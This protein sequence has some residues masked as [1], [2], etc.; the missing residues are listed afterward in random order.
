[1]VGYQNAVE[2]DV[3]GHA[4]LTWLGSYQHSVGERTW[5]AALHYIQSLR[6][7]KVKIAFFNS[8]PQGGGVALMRHALVRFFRIMGVDCT[9]YV[10]KPKPE[11]FRITKTNH[12]I[13]Q[14]V[15]APEERLTEHRKQILQDWCYQNARRFWLCEGGPL[16][17]RSEGGADIVIVDDPQMPDLVL[18]AKESDPDRPVIFRSHIQIRSDLADVEGTPT[19]EVWEWMWKKV[20]RADLFISHPVRRFVPKDVDV[21]KVGYMPATTDWMDGLNKDMD[22]YTSG[23][24][25]FH[26]VLDQSLP[27]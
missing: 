7:R 27:F 14:G 11:V 13:L 18:L 20:Q 9:W 8:T 22:Q 2:V 17:P 26:S 25:K 3:D 12:N 6:D 16:R 5:D 4:Q 23:Y 15:A 10:P 21:K 24:C 1:M 19:N